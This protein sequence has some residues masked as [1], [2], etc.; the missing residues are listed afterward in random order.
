MA[1]LRHDIRTACK[2]ARTSRNRGNHGTAPSMGAP[3]PTPWTTKLARGPV[4]HELKMSALLTW[5]PFLL[6]PSHLS[7][8]RSQ[9]H[10]RIAEGARQESACATRALATN[11]HAST[12][13]GAVHIA[14]LWTRRPASWKCPFACE[15]TTTSVSRRPPLRHLMRRRPSA[16]RLLRRVTGQLVLPASRARGR[17]PSGAVCGHPRFRHRAPHPAESTRRVSPWCGKRHGRPIER[18]R[19]ALVSS[20]S[21]A[22][23]AACT[24]PGSSS[25]RDPPAPPCF[26]WHTSPAAS[27]GCWRGSA[28]RSSP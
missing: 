7:E 28:L 5:N 12:E 21:A 13:T 4:A 17:G 16:S 8:R 23:H 11:T 6:L 3:T 25:R 19:A 10:G 9:A 18:K 15:V 27:R 14:I 26:A 22:P 24:G 1:K 20:V 2:A